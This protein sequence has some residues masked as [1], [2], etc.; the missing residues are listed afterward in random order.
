MTHNTENNTQPART[1]DLVLAADPETPGTHTVRMDEAD[2]RAEH[3]DLAE[4]APTDGILINRTRSGISPFV[5]IRKER[6]VDQLTGA[7]S[8]SFGIWVE[9]P[10]S[11]SGWRDMGAVSERY[12]LLP[13]ADVRR[14]SL[15]IAEASGLAYEES[16]LFWDGSRFAQ[17]IDFVDTRAEV[18][19]GDPVGLSLV[20]RSSYDRSWAYDAALMGKRFAC[21]NGVLTGEFF[22]R[23]TFRH[24]ETGDGEPWQAVVRQGLGLLEHAEG[25]LR[26]FASALRRLHQTSMTDEH[27]RAVWRRLPQITDTAAGRILRRYATEEEPTLYGLLNAGTHTF[28]HDPKM[29]A[30]DFGYNATFVDG[31]LE[32]ARTHIN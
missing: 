14:L 31:L 8:R 9:D 32:Y 26:A 29:S 12:L 25:D 1:D 30:S 6:L 18:S 23:V 22:S 17:I 7:P 15:E 21:D 19:D 2:G 5:R 20:T 24:T 10:E 13:N 11:D 27:W 4:I 28:W 16:R 3:R